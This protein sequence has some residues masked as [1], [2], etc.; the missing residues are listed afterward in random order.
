MTQGGQGGYDNK[1]DVYAFGIMLAEALLREIPPGL[2]STFPVERI[3]AVNKP[4]AMLYERCIMRD[5]NARPK[6]SQISDF[7]EDQ[8]LQRYL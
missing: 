3:M 8:F 6:Q 2:L 7:L 4:L 1:V 5:P